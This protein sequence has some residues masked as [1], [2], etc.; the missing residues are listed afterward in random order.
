MLSKSSSVIDVVPTE[1]SEQLEPADLL[2]TAVAL[3]AAVAC[4]VS[5][6]V[7]L[8]QVDD[9]DVDQLLRTEGFL[10]DQ[11]LCTHAHPGH[12]TYKAHISA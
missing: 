9:S 12:Q 3:L 1:E 10:Q 7:E 2:I 8:K 4:Q 6:V 11:P 5:E